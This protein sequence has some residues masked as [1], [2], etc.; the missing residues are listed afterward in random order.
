MYEDKI[1]KKRV[2]RMEEVVQVLQIVM[3][4]RIPHVFEHSKRLQEFIIPIGVKLKLSE[5]AV[6]DL[7]ISAL[8][9]DIGKLGIPDALLC[10]KE[11]LTEQEIKRM[12]Q[13]TI[14]GY[15]L[16]RN[17]SMLSHIAEYVLYHHE[18]W[19]GN[20]YPEGLK[21]DGIPYFSRI[22]SLVDAYDAMIC[23]RPYRRAMSEEEANE[24]I[25]MGANNQFDPE[26]VDLF[27]KNG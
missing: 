8:F 24:E 18:R 25:K 22:I 13:H 3:R 11:V 9:H 4:E 6:A 1:R 20:G 10:K 5:S 26:L 12:K 17:S 15:E 21:G 27:F 2:G 7:S 23:N 14:F 16:L 19:D